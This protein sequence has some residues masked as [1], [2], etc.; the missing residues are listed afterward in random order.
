MVALKYSGCSL[1]RQRLSASTLSG[2]ALR[3]DKIR[4]KDESPGLQD[5]EASYLRLIEKLS[6][7]LFYLLFSLIY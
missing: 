3:I 7:G 1:F 2:S 6:D 4:E 5:F